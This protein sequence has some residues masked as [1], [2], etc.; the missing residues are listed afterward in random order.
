MDPMGYIAPENKQNP[1]RKFH[2]PLI[3]KGENVSF[4]E[5]MCC[6]FCCFK[7]EPLHSKCPCETRSLTCFFFETYCNF[8]CNRE[9]AGMPSPRNMKK[10]LEGPGIHK[11][12][13][14]VKRMKVGANLS[15]ETGHF[16]NCLALSAGV[17]QSQII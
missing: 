16:R 3:F 1:K 13:L 15:R 12:P 8:L 2:L 10:T 7:K 11:G 17:M 9:V 4:R 14:D 6:A 5:G